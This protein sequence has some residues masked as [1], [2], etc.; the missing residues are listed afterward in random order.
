VPAG[1]L[2]DRVL[3]FIEY[4]NITLAKPFKWTYKG[5]P[6]SAEPTKD[7]CQ[8]ALEASPDPEV[9]GERAFSHFLK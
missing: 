9:A 6:L 5:R 8:A 7:F 2:H 4:C 3:A 1:G